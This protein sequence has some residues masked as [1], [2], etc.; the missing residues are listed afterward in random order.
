MDEIFAKPPRMLTTTLTSHIL[1]ILPLQKVVIRCVHMR[2]SIV[3]FDNFPWWCGQKTA[4]LLLL[5][6]GHHTRANVL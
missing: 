6:E 5:C 2:S 1:C 4:V 3:D